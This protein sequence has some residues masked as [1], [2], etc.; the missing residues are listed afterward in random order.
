[1]ITLFLLSGK[2]TDKEGKKL[3]EL[4]HLESDLKMIFTP[5]E[6]Y[7]LAA[8]GR[9]LGYEPVINNGKKDISKKK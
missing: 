4:K 1:M 7:E 3:Y 9:I 5:Q 6:A 8:I 2:R